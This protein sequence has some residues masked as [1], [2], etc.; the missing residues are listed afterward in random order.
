MRVPRTFGGCLKLKEEKE[1][2]HDHQKARKEKN[3]KLKNK[4]NPKQIKHT[5]MQEIQLYE[6]LKKQCEGRGKGGGREKEN[7]VADK[8]DRS[9]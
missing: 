2:R 9:D 3:S 4:N 6:R 1:S 8:R 5:K 7:G